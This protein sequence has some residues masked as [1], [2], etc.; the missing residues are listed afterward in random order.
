MNA[1]TAAL[2]AALTEQ[3]DHVL[4]ILDG[5]DDDALRRPVLP[6]G[7]T[8]LGLVRHLT[9]DVERFWFSV[10][11]DGHPDLLVP[12]DAW[13]AADLPAATV[14]DEYRQEIERADAVIAATPLSRPPAWWPDDFGDWRLRDLRETLLH[15]VT[16]TACHAGHLDAVR[17]LLDGHRWLVLT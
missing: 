15:V 10:V 3:R 12:G 7:W 13:D 14:L 9:L 16:E 8:C 17:E 1:E 11:T 4:G 2:H 6:S 5:L